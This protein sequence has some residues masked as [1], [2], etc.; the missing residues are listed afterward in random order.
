M[1]QAQSIG[2]V[3]SCFSKSSELGLSHPFTRRR[4]CPPFGSGEGEAHSLAGEGVGKSQFRRLEKKLRTLP[5]LCLKRRM[6][7]KR[8]LRSWAHNPLC[9]KPAPPRQLAEPST[10]LRVRGW[11]RP[12]S[13]D[14]E[15][16]LSTLPAQCL[17]QRTLIGRKLSAWPHNH[18]CLKPPPPPQR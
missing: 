7:I 12:S 5:T 1:F 9:L 6:I 13:D 18:I 14:L 16:K 8:K 10:R 2:R 15:K 3:L 17:K 11:G 4:V